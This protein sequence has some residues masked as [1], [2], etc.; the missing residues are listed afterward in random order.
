MLPRTFGDQ[1]FDLERL[2]VSEEL[3]GGP[4]VRTS[5]GIGRRSQGHA[6]REGVAAAMTADGEPALTAKPV[7]KLLIAALAACA[8]LL[9]LITT[10]VYVKRTN[11][12][13]KRSDDA[14]PEGRS[15]ST[16][17][18]AA[19]DAAKAAGPSAADEDLQALQK[20]SQ[21][22]SNAGPLSPLRNTRLGQSLWLHMN[23]QRDSIA[24]GEQRWFGILPSASSCRFWSTTFARKQRSCINRRGIRLLA[25]TARN[26]GRGDGTRVL[27]ESEPFDI[28]KRLGG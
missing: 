8:I 25:G 24:L 6:H 15:S 21:E 7:P 18:A 12:R 11:D 27:S 13:D 9:A 23:F 2:G 19:V 3:S 17:A 20:H 1:V 16:D 5:S 10:V 4:A 28:G 26:G 14:A 22:L